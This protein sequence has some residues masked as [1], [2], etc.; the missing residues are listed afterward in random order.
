MRLYK[1]TLMP[2]QQSTLSP[3]PSDIDTQAAVPLPIDQIAADAGILPEELELYG[4]TKAKFHLSILDRLKASPNG[5]YIVVTAIT[6]TPL[7]EGKTTTTTVGLSQSLGAHLGNKVFTCVR[8]P[9]QRP[10]FG[11]IG[12]AAG[13]SYSQFIPMEDFNLC[14]TGDIHAITAAKNLLAAAIDTR[15]FHEAT[16]NDEALF[17]RLCAPA[18]YDVDLDLKTGRVI[19]LA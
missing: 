7:S 3:V 18:Y 1:L 10:T 17:N 13:G 15:L 14:L 11:S 5:K 8:Q 12:G 19:G 6:P 9:S 4:R 2:S 16:Q